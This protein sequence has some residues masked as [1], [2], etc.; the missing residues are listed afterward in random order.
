MNNVNV[1]D[2]LREK[3]N[4]NVNESIKDFENFKS[5]ELYKNK[6]QFG[7][8]REIEKI[9]VYNILG[10][11]IDTYSKAIG[12]VNQVEGEYNNGW[13]PCSDRLPSSEDNNVDDFMMNIPVLVQYKDYSAIP[14]VLTYNTYNKIFT[15]GH[16]DFTKEIIAWQPLPEPYKN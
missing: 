9:P 3:L 4:Q 10:A 7:G 11:R 13:I 1:F 15:N 16:T 6:L 12:I 2:I 8:Y 14:E 5:S